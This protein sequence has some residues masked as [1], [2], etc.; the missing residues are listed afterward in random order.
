MPSLS[1]SNYSIILFTFSSF[2]PMVSVGSSLI[3]S[4]SS[5]FVSFPSF[6]SSNFEKSSS[7]SFMNCFSK[8]VGSLGFSESFC[9]SILL[10]FNKFI[11]ASI[12]GEETSHL[13]YVPR[14]P[15]S[16]A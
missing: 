12:R 9:M 10:I 15:T 5:Y 6:T 7:I 3:P 8:S 11:N 16:V 2:D 14:S 13:Q 4:I 1:L